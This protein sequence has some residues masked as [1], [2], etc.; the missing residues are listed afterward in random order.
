MQKT[1]TTPVQPSPDQRDVAFAAWPLRADLDL[2]AVST[3]PGCARAWSRQILWEWRQTSL[4]EQT[5]LIVSELITNAL[6]AS[7]GLDR[8]AI[9]L[10]LVSDYEQL[11]VLVRDRAPEAPAPRQATEDD[12]RG[13][14]LLL[15]ESMSARFGWFRAEDGIP[16]KVIWAEI[17]A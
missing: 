4:S 8:P 11:V 6:N 5:T 17:S 14:G 3:A 7:Q 9:L 1:A 15:V 2:G 13:R 16:G 10:T 12:E